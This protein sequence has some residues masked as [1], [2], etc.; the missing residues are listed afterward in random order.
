VTDASPRPALSAEDLRDLQPVHDAPADAPADELG[1]C[2]SGGGYRAMLFHLGGLWRLNECALLKDLKRV[3]SVSGGSITAATLGLNWGGLDWR[4][5]VAANLDELV[6]A[7]VR[8]LADETIDVSSVLE[9][10][11]PF[12]SVGKRVA[13]A[14]REHLFG[15]ATLQALPDDE[16]AEGPRFVICATNLESGVL[17]RFSR[18]Y[19]ADYRVGTIRTPEIELADAVAA[20]SAFPPI[21]S[22]FEID[23][24][25]ADWETV[26]GNELVE[27]VWRGKV[28]LSDGGVYDNLG[29]ETVWKRCR[30]V[31]VSDAGGQLTPDP[32]PDH[33]WP[34]HFVRVLRVIDNQVRA[35]RKGQTIL[36]LRRGDRDGVYLGIRSHLA[37]YHVEDPLPAPPERTILLA[38]VPTRLDA[39]EETLQERL[40]NW[41]YAICDAGLRRHLDPGAARPLGFPYPEAAV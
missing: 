22:P 1:L 26:A 14:Y 23:L 16:Q 21:L 5:G 10:A 2:L 27:P 4:D 34:L 6:I 11:L 15:E 28:K 8:A 25:R 17:F 37:D 35:L 40:V 7:P 13:H 18:P 19:A 41:G 3:S 12:T 30:T 31:I 24:R 32:R 36:S 39:L 9:G 20:S 33:D 29:L 38:D